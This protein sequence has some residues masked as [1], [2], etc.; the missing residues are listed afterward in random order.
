LN[1]KHADFFAEWFTFDKSVKEEKA[2]VVDDVIIDVVK[3]PPFKTEEDVIFIC[4]DVESWERSHNIITEIGI[5]TLDTAD[6]AY[7][8][9]GVE[10]ENWRAAIRSRHFRI[11]EHRKYR[12]HSFVS[13]CAD[14]FHFG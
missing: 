4:V 3:P 1:I 6:I 8:A 10:G 9:P 13:D 7:L 11:D 2:V 5:A 12:N 14:N